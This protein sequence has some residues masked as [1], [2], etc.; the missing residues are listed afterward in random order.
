MK[1]HLD[2]VEQANRKMGNLAVL[3]E[4]AGKELKI[5]VE[6]RLEVVLD[7]IVNSSTG[8]FETH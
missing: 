6:R 8:F 2:F 5:S 1:L 4:K 7:L 3:E